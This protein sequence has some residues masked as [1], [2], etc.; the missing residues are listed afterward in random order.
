MLVSLLTSPNNAI[1][2]LKHDIMAVHEN[3]EIF[4]EKV[5]APDA[6]R[7]CQNDILIFATFTSTYYV[8]SKSVYFIQVRLIPILP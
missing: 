2:I 6:W 5:S 3:I 7:L 1:T 8:A 4:Y